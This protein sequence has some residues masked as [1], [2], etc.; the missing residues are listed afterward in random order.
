MFN[1]LRE[2]SAFW[3]GT[4]VGDAGPY[5]RAIINEIFGTLVTGDR[6]NQGVIMIPGG[7]NLAVSSPGDFT[8]RVSAGTAI[9]DGTWYNNSANLDL[10]A[11]VIVSPNVAAVRIDTVS[12][13]KDYSAKTVRAVI[14][15]GAP[16]TRPTT[17]PQQQEPSRK[18]QLPLAKYTMDISGT[19]TNVIDLRVP[20][21]SAASSIFPFY[22]TSIANKSQVVVRDIPQLYSF[23]RFELSFDPINDAEG[24]IKQTATSVRMQMNED[25]GA[26]VYSY[27]HSYRTSSGVTT[28]A[29]DA[30]SSMLLATV[31]TYIIPSGGTT[32]SGYIV[33]RNNI[34]LSTGVRTISRFESY[35]GDQILT[36]LSAGTYNSG[37]SKDPVT[38]LT[39]SIDAGTFGTNAEGCT[40]KLYGY[41]T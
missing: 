4:F 6:R 27:T 10:T 15:P 17:P 37:T 5:G 1:D 35:S 8:A 32:I 25:S 34:T 14:V 7:T 2:K 22:T 36:G 20:V 3:E 31:Y 38:S 41:C 23:I 39:F 21:L 28:T 9:V 13:E 40:L 16:A 19:I 29:D 26:S 24:F 33:N 12:L 30:N 11:P 18:F